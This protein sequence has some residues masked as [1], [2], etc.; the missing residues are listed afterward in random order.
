M[1]TV[2]NPSMPATS[3]AGVLDRFE[4]PK[5]FFIASA[6]FEPERQSRKELSHLGSVRHVL[7]KRFENRKPRARTRSER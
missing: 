1:A 5:I 7:G 3:T 6:Q 4:P 2:P